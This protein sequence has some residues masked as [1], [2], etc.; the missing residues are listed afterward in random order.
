[1]PERTDAQE[2]PT[3]RRLLVRRRRSLAALAALILLVTLGYAGIRLARSA[4][5]ADEAA[6]TRPADRA[7]SAPVSTEAQADGA[8]DDAAT[9]TPG[10]A[11]DDSGATATPS[12]SGATADPAMPSTLPESGSGELSVLRLPGSD[13]GREGRRVRYTVEI[14]GGLGVPEQHFAAVVRK[15]LTDFRGWE[16]QDGVRFVNV[17][18]EQRAQGVATDVRIILGSPAYVDAGCRPLRTMGHLSCHSGGKVLLNV[19]RWARG[20]DTYDDVTAYRTYLINH[21]VGHALGHSHRACPGQGRRA[22]VMV[23]QTKSLYGCEPWPWPQPQTDR[24]G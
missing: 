11:T 13:S 3:R 17:P 9:P 15:V 10:S 7:T 19:R 22:P 8:A 23:Q 12:A 21:E 6:A 5:T 24:T 2:R 18:P 4:D 14:E 20:A 1:M 16:P